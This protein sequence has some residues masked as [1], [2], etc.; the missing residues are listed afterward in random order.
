MSAS[1]K[2]TSHSASGGED[3]MHLHSDNGELIADD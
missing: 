2:I 3:T 1:S